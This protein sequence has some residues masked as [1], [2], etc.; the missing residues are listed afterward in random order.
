MKSWLQIQLP[1]AWKDARGVADGIVRAAGKYVLNLSANIKHFQL[2]HVTEK[3]LWV[4]KYPP[5]S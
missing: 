1:T 2:T 5:D 4:Q 3:A